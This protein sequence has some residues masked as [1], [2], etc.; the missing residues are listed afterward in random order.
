MGFLD[1]YGNF[2]NPTSWGI[3]VTNEG[4]FFHQMGS[5]SLHDANLVILDPLNLQNNTTKNS[6]Q[7]ASILKTFQC[8]HN[9]MKSLIM[10]KV[11]EAKNF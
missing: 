5:I 4:S 1:F 10:K 7:T 3:N 9:N 2:F 11:A 6:Y 8:T